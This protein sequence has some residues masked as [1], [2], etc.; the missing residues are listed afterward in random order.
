MPRSSHRTP[1]R[2]V[3][4]LEPEARE[5]LARSAGDNHRPVHYE[6][7]HLVVRGLVEGG[8]LERPAPSASHVGRD[9]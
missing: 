8:Y 3:L 2:I 1:A 5:A 4:P 7:E 6:A 9:P